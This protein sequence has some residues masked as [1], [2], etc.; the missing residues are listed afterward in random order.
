[1]NLTVTKK[2]PFTLIVLVCV[3]S[4]SFGQLSSESTK[5]QKR[6]IRGQVVAEWSDLI[7]GVCW[8]VCGMRLLVAS[9]ETNRDMYIL[10][11]VEYFDNR[12]LPKRGKPVQLL[13]PGT[14]WKFEGTAEVEKIRLEQYL[15]FEENGRDATELL[16]VPGWRFLPGYANLQLPFGEE[17]PYL[18]VSLANKY[19]MIKN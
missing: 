19:K 10:I 9:H 17:I 5:R 14:M 8:H 18:R 16:K 3:F 13:T 2:L 12:N 1:M 11:D 6:T 15:R 7:S 4:I